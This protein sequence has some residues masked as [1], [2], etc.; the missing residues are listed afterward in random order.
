MC[1]VIPASGVMESSAGSPGGGG[2]AETERRGA[3][4]KISLTDC[5]V[6]GSD[7]AKYRC[8]ACLTHSC[9]VL[10]VK[11]HKED[12]GCSGVR[13]KTAF[14]PLSH[15]DEMAL[16]NDYRFLEDAGR[17]VDGTK[18][19]KL[20]LNP[21]ITMKAKRMIMYARRM[22]ITL[23][24]LPIAFTKSRENSTFFLNRERQFLWHLKLMFPQCSSEFSQMRVSDQK[25]LEQILTFYIHPTESNPVAR[26]K[27][28]LYVRPTFDDVKVFM[29]VEEDEADSVRYHEFEL[30]KSLRENLSY[31]TLVEYPELHV[32]LK[33]QWE[34][35][36]TKAPAEPA[37]TRSGPATKNAV[38]DQKTGAAI[39]PSSLPPRSC[40]PWATRPRPCSLWATSLP[41]KKNEGGGEEKEEVEEGEIIGS[42]E[43]EEEEEEE[44][45]VSCDKSCGDPKR[46]AGDASLNTDETAGCIEQPEDAAN[47]QR[48]VRRNITGAA[49]DTSAARE[50]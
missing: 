33:D 26:Q 7:E 27:L 14:L 47:T 20:V 24:M 15:F 16:L 35:Y 46:P 36:P 41:T 21:R 49:E 39:Q 3:K 8:P 18:R 30:K 28:M 43:E 25:T 13:N 17:F 31:T 22:N 37:P 2:G 9:S 32:V 44:E 19:D 10:C 42:S 50:R 12:S 5:A 23:R 29:K 34:N 45:N 1:S 48:S 6:C 38:V 4:R 40:S 11:K